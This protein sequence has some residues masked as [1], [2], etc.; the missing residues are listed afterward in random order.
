MRRVYIIR[1][2]PGS[3]KSTIAK[4][5]AKA[6]VADGLS[7]VIHTTDDYHMVDGKYCYDPPKSK[8]YHRKNFLAFQCSCRKGI[9][10]VV[11]PNTNIHKGQYGRYEECAKEHGYTVFKIV[12]DEFSIRT[13]GR[14]TEHKMPENII[15]GMKKDF[16]FDNKAVFWGHM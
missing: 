15:Y 16:E 2:L 6:A 9:A 8:E 1:G 11:C 14:R 4:E 3:G 10:V 13:A 7:V 12:M 5:L